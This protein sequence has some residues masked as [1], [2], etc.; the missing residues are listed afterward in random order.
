M[1]VALAMARM[2]EVSVMVAGARSMTVAVAVANARARARAVVVAVAVALVVAVAV[3]R[4]VPGGGKD[5]NRSVAAKIGSPLES[6]LFMYFISCNSE[7]AQQIC[8]KDF[9]EIHR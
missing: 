5:C 3:A 9:L 7:K 4:T 2:R 8:L 1:A 6:D